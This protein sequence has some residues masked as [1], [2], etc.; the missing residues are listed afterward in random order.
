M[1]ANVRALRYAALADRA[2]LCLAVDVREGRVSGRRVPGRLNLSALN[3]LGQG[4][5][6]G[7]QRAHLLE[8]RRIAAAPRP[9]G[10]AADRDDR[11]AAALSDQLGPV[12]PDEDRAGRGVIGA[13]RE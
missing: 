6:L 2:A 7:T 11:E 8:H 5:D 3:L 1:I 12:F 13:R 4:R 10:M 9:S